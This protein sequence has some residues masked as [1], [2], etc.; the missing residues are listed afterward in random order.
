MKKNDLRLK[1]IAAAGLLALCALGFTGCQQA[2][3]QPLS[4]STIIN[5]GT[6]EEVDLS[7]I[8]CTEDVT[9]SRAVKI[10]NGDFGGKTLTVN[11]SGVIL[12]NAKNV[13][14]V[15]AES[16]GDGDFTASTS[17]VS[18]FKVLGGGANSI[19]VKDTAVKVINIAKANV[20]VALE[21]K[22][23]VTKLQLKK[24]ITA[25]V[26]VKSSEVK[27]EAAEVVAEDGLKVEG[28]SVQ[29]TVDDGVTF[30][31]PAGSVKKPSDNHKHT[32][33]DWE[34]VKAPTCTEKG[35]KKRKC[36]GCDK[37]ETA[38]IDAKG[39]SFAAE[40]ETDKDNHWHKATCGHDTE[41]S[42][43]GAHVDSDSDGKC[44]ACSFDMTADW[45]APEFVF[46]QDPDGTQFMAKENTLKRPMTKNRVPFDGTYLIAIPE[47]SSDGIITFKD[48]SYDWKYIKAECDYF[49]FQD[50]EI[51]YGDEDCYIIYDEIKAA[52]DTA[53]VKM[54][55]E[56]FKQLYLEFK[57]IVDM[58]Y[59]E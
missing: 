6:S 10:K 20:R 19:H 50:N 46:D 37:E 45:P 52:C 8:P 34:T 54:D 1:M 40:W 30:T 39:H 15:V 36:T 59:A 12:E 25:K 18:S 5:R 26:E 51:N 57:N 2:T 24:G 29:I 16:V 17:D 4:I 31:V 42:A 9:V 21:G 7:N 55:P 48:T 35:Q 28:E 43:L 23:T 38:E 13:D 22:S 32:Y 11:V 3:Q 27:V 33:G 58:Y 41:K 14:V 56:K 49:Y 47:I 44:D 53:H